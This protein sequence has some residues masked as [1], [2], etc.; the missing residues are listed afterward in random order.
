MMYHIIMRDK[1]DFL[2]AACSGLCMIHCL[3]LPILATTGMSFT[4]L[5][6]LSGESIHLWLNVAM[7]I[8]ALLAFPAGWRIH[9]M[10]L[11]SLLAF[12]GTGLMAIAVIVPENNEIY[13][14]ISSGVSFIS[15]HLFNRYFLTLRNIK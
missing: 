4:G 14:V 7:L 11:P 3:G 9:K 5:T 6:Y 10:K 8:I 2:G 13:W 1:K 12:I 15:G